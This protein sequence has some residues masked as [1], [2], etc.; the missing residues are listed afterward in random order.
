MKHTEWE[1]DRRPWKFCTRW[2]WR[3]TTVVILFL[4]VVTAATFLLKWLFH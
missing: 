1:R 2:H 4:S 3:R